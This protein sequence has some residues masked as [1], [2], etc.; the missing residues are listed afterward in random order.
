MGE[1]CERHLRTTAAL[2]VHDVAAEGETPLLPQQF[3]NSSP[4][5]LRPPRPHPQNL[6]ARQCLAE[7]LGVSAHCHTDESTAA[8]AAAATPAVATAAA[9]EDLAQ[10]GSIDLS[11]VHDTETVAIHTGSTAPIDANLQSCSSNETCGADSLV[12]STMSAST[13][14]WSVTLRSHASAQ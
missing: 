8:S 3:E 6:A 4:S 10:S 2:P 11:C 14:T 7:P 1:R 13:C 5:D 9:S 12:V